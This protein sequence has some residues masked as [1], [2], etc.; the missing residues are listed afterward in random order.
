MSVQRKE[1]AKDK[2]APD[3]NEPAGKQP[4]P[5]F[6]KPLGSSHNDEADLRDVAQEAARKS[7]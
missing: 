5:N 6:D 1:A 2:K 4:K 3:L 7:K